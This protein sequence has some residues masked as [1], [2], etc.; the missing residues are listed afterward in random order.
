MLRCRDVI[1]KTAFIGGEFVQRVRARVRGGVRRAP[2][3]LRARTAP[4]RSTSCCGCSASAP[5]DEVIT[6]AASWIS[7]SETISQTGATPVFVDVDEYFN[8]DVEQVA[9]RITPTHASD[10]PRAPLW[11]G[12][13]GRGARQLAA[14]SGHAPDR[15]LR[16]GALCRAGG[17]SRGHVRRRRDVQLLSRQEPRRLRRR[18]RDH[19]ERRRACANAAA[20]TPTTARW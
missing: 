4:T 10:H 3:R 6:T 1:A 9:A 16:T 13:A 14:A 5:G 19:H 17:S 7:T 11:P 12:G 8:I 20:C 15:G 18:G 2:L